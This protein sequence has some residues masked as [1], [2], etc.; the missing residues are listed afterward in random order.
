MLLLNKLLGNIVGFDIGWPCILVCMWN[1]EV[2]FNKNMSGM[3][4][5]ILLVP[6]YAF[7]VSR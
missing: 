4:L 6:K 5:D 7:A 2:L 1:K 3:D